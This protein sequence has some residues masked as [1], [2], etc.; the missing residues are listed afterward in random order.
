MPD[1]IKG[2]FD[3]LRI[4]FSRH[5]RRRAKLYG[6]VEQDIVDIVNEKIIE[7]DRI[8]IIVNLDKYTHAIKVIAAR[9]GEDVMIIT[10]Y[11]LKK[12]LKNESIL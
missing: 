4:Q 1:I 8:E 9:S 7:Q 2:N 12:G 3:L 11:P 5:A 10:C 6:I